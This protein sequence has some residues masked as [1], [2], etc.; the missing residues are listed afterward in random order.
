MDLPAALI[1]E[2]QKGLLGSSRCESAISLIFTSPIHMLVP[3]VIRSF[4]FE[5]H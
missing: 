3:A 4:E 5:C 1:T 2:L